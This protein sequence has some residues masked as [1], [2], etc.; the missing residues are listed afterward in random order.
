MAKIQDSILLIG[1]GGHA[2][3]CID[4]IEQEGKYCVI[5][6]IGLPTEIGKTLLTYP[7]FGEDNDLPR[8]LKNN[9]NALIGIGQIKSAQSRIRMF[10]YL[11]SFACHMPIIVS[12]NAY[13]SPYAHLGEGTIVMSGATINAGVTIGKNCIINSHSLVEHDVSVGHHCHISTSCTLN[14]GVRIGDGT[15]IGSGSIVREMVKI[16]SHCVVGMGQIV[17]KDCVDQS[18]IPMKKEAKHECG[19]YS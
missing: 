19:D 7:I 18:Y 3:S 15:F 13:V 14:G 2:K 17:L 10:E 6:C 12:P 11:K 5:G 8:L 1:A 9:S 4:V 16:G